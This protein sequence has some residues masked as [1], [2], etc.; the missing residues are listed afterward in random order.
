VRDCGWFQTRAPNDERARETWL[1][2]FALRTYINIPLQIRGHRYTA[3]VG[4]SSSSRI[5]RIS[6]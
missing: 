3:A 5:E 2:C 4:Q 6:P 1:F